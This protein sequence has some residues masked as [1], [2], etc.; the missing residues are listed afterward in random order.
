MRGGEG[1]RGRA[2]LPASRRARDDGDPDPAHRG[3]D[4]LRRSRPDRARRAAGGPDAGDDALARTGPSEYPAAWERVRKEIAAGHQAYVICPLVGG[5]QPEDEE[6]ETSRTPSEDDESELDELGRGTG[7]VRHPTL[8]WRARPGGERGT[9][10]AAEVGGGGARA[11]FGRASSPGSRSVCCTVSSPRRRRRPRW[12]PSARGEI[13]V[14]VATTVIEVGVDV[15]ER[16]RDGDRGRRPFRHRPAPP[17]PG[18]GRARQGQVL[19]LPAGRVRHAGRGAATAGARGH[20]ATGSSSPRST[21]SCGA[22][23][24]CS[25]SG[26]RAGATCASPRCAGTRRSSERPAGWPRPSSTRTRP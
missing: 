15:A 5:G 19:V 14:L 7:A 22:R 20:R 13:Q 10:A 17:A 6:P 26:K 8:P 24:P 21:S 16:D 12:R 4:R 18:P 2:G 3:H 1:T 9:Q 11:A 23:A 25:G